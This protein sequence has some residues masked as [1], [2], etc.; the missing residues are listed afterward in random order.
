MVVQPNTL[1]RVA[2]TYIAT[3]GNPNI[4]AD[5]QQLWWLASPTTGLATL[6][7]IGDN[8]GHILLQL[9]CYA[10]LTELINCCWTYWALST[11][12][13]PHLWLQC[14]QS[15]DY[16]LETLPHGDTPSLMSQLSTTIT[17]PHLHWTLLASYQQTITCPAIPPVPTGSSLEA[18]SSPSLWTV[19]ATLPS[20]LC[21]S[22][23]YCQY[24]H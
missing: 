15:I 21:Y 12:P 1:L 14:T 17:W 3:F 13:S 22:Y 16:T 2:P 6:Q 9:I 8:R 24:H 20:P 11:S 4:D 23:C 10:Q 7:T 19:K 18:T 5:Q